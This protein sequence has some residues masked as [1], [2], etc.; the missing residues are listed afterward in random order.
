MTNQAASGRAG[1]GAST[2]RFRPEA[3]A[4][5]SAFY[6]YSGEGLPVFILAAFAKNEKADLSVAERSVLSKMVDD[7]IKGYR[8]R[9]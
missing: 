8:R 7:M 6:L 9:K 3:L 1:I 5:Y 2:L 4:A